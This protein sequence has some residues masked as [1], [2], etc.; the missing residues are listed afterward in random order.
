MKTILF[1]SAFILIGLDSSLF[2]QSGI[3]SNIDPQAP[4]L[5]VT[6]SPEIATEYIQI[7]GNFSSAFLTITDQDGNV[8]ES[9]LIGDGTTIDIKRWYPGVYILTVDD[10]SY[11]ITQKVVYKTMY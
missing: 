11:S 8:V 4:Q 3:S 9:C 2:A 5:I 10:G 1:I 7:N 6:V